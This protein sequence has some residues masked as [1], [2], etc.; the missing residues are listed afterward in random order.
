MEKIDLKDRKILYHLDLDSRQ[1]LSKI[2]K[3]VGLPKNVV[4]Y[5]IKRLKEIGVIKN[6]FAVIDLHKL[7]YTILRFYFKYQYVTPEIKEEIINYFKK[8]KHAG[9]IHSVEGSYDLVIYMF[10]K[11][12]NEF[13]PLWE[14]TL[15]KYRDYFSTQK[16]SHYYREFCY[17]NAFLLNNNLNRKR[18]EIFKG[19]NKVEIDDIDVKIIKILASNARTP[20]SDIAKKLKLSTVTI[21]NRIKKLIDREII[22]WFRTNIDFT[23]IGYRWYKVDIALKDHKKLYQIINY[24]KNNPNFISVDRTIGYVDLEIEFFLKDIG[25]IHKIM[26]D[27]SIKFPNTIRNY[28]YIYVIESNKYEF[29]PTV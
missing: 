21:A 15:S 8:F 18:V 4:S 2:G 11:N 20:A 16:L 6:F 9:I 5:R 29:F 25:Q 22:Q 13:Y 14:E 17:N 19:I 1:P 7:G 10:I 27:L 28:E 3:K 12:V 23:K 26:E 24:L